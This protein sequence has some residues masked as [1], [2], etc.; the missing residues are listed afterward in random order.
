M[1]WLDS[2][3]AG[4]IILAPSIV[5]I[6]WNPVCPGCGWGKF[7]TS[8]TIS[9]GTLLGNR[10]FWL[11]RRKRGHALTPWLAKWLGFWKVEMP[12][13]YFLLSKIQYNK[14]EWR[15]EWYESNLVTLS[16]TD[17]RMTSAL[18]LKRE[19]NWTLTIITDWLWK[20]FVRPPSRKLLRINKR[21]TYLIA[22][23]RKLDLR[24]LLL[25]CI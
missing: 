12:T 4:T 21:W 7:S 5:T 13:I 2:T 8:S 17:P 10:I 25:I 24:K 22:Q 15:W 14:F 9:M 20:R 11:G 1:N 3:L 6:H 19:I 18:F 16:K 23:D